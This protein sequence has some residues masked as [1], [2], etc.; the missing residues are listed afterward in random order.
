MQK[1]LLVVE[2]AVRVQGTD[3]RVRCRGGGKQRSHR[4]TFSGLYVCLRSGFGRWCGRSRHSV[5]SLG[6]APKGLH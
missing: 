6:T 5:G 3:G 1:V 2:K 4:K